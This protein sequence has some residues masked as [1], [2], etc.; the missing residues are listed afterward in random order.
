MKWNGKWNEIKAEIKPMKALSL[1]TSVFTKITSKP[2]L[3]FS[4]YIFSLY[5]PI[6]NIYIYLYR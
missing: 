1:S 6:W 5:M 3:S 4:L 2:F